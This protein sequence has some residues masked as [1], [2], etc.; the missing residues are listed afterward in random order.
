MRIFNKLYGARTRRYKTCGS[1][2]DLEMDLD[3]DPERI[4]SGSRVDLE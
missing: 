2:D 4:L 1:Q 3:V